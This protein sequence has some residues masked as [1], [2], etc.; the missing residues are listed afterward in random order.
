LGFVGYYGE[1]LDWASQIYAVTQDPSQ[2][3]R[4]GNARIRAQIVKMELARSNFRYPMVDPDGNRAMVMETIVGWRDDHYPAEVTYAERSAWEGSALSATAV[5]LDARALGFVGQMIA[6]NQLYAS[7]E[8]LISQ[9][10]TR[11]SKT[12][13]LIPGELDTVLKSFTGSARLPMSSGSPDFIFSDEEDGVVA[14]HH[15]SEILYASLYWRSG[16][17]INHLARV[18]DIQPDTDHLA[19]V[20]GETEFVD[21]GMRVERHDAFAFG[22]GNGGPRYPDDFKSALTGLSSPI[23]AAEPTSNESMPPMRNTSPGRASFYTLR[24]G[25][26]VIG[27]NTTAGKTY[28]LSVPKSVEKIIDLGSGKRVRAGAS[29]SV[30]PQTTT[31]LWVQGT[32]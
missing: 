30:P 21:S 4:V 17:A 10:G 8:D 31:V 25:R 5:T 16:D 24:Y 3:E 22:F 23:A 19:T 28:S 26:Y 14:I 32:Q 13:L 9:K 2:P 11:V 20:W 1:V 29:L 27:M 7:I 12:L 15:G 6:D 18:H